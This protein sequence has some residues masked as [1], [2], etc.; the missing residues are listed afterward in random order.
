LRRGLLALA[1]FGTV[2]AAVKLKR[3]A[4]FD[5]AWTIRLQA[6]KSPELA[7]L[8]RAASWPG[9]PP[10]SRVIPPL[11]VGGLWAAGHGFEARFQAA[12]WATALFSTVIKA[13]VR[14]PRPLPPQ[15]QVVVAPLGGTSFPSG[16]VL[17]YVG[18]YGFL[19]YLASVLIRGAALRRAVVTPLVA[20]VALVGPSRIH[21]GHH[22]PTDVLASYLLGLGYVE[23]LIALYDRL[24]RDRAQA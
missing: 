4:E 24:K 9:F 19:A 20:L 10:Q 23:L 14:R 5:L 3:T 11:I 1:G 7:R 2:F 17:T 13:A 22:W 6:E 16:H 18:V 15:V 8:M 21:E 12:A